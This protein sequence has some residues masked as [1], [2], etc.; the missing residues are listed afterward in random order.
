ML[1]FGLMCHKM[2]QC[3]IKTQFLQLTLMFLLKIF[4]YYFMWNHMKDGSLIIW[5]NWE[6]WGPR[7]VQAE[8]IVTAA[9]W[10]VLKHFPL[11]NQNRISKHFFTGMCEILALSNKSDLEQIGT[12]SDNMQVLPLHMKITIPLA[13]PRWKGLL[14]E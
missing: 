2:F 9:L 8:S 1:G 7:Q 11:S 5:G 13:C 6:S 12:S 14:K 3:W 10:C 4:L